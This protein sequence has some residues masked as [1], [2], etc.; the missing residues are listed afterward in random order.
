MPLRRSVALRPGGGSIGRGEQV[1]HRER[2]RG[3]V[4]VIPREA[5]I[6]G[7]DDLPGLPLVGGHHDQPAVVTQLVDVA[8]FVDLDPLHTAVA[9]DVP[10]RFGNP[11]R[12]EAQ[13]KQHRR[14]QTNGESPKNLRAY[15]RLMPRSIADI[16]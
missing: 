12:T 4:E 10:A 1:V 9:A 15:I 6:P 16:L 2:L 5:L 14:S 13:I 11:A 3:H 8:A 7:E